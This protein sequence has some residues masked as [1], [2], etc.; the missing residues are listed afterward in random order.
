MV[1]LRPS[2]RIL[3]LIASVGIFIGSIAHGDPCSTGCK[4]AHY[5]TGNFMGTGATYYSDKVC[6]TGSDCAG[7]AVNVDCELVQTNAVLAHA[8]YPCTPECTS[9]D[10]GGLYREMTCAS[11]VGEYHLADLKKCD[12]VIPPD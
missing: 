11:Y 6:V 10:C 3:A 9:G 8:A 2:H 5:W 12:N 4:N 7:G 1:L